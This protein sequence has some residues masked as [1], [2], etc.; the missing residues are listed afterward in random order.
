M[1]RKKL[2]AHLFEE[3][4]N[5]TECFDVKKANKLSSRR[6]YDHKINLILEVKLRTQKVYELAKNQAFVIKAYVNEMLKKGFIRSSSFRFAAPVLVVKKFGEGLRVCIDY[7]SLNALIIKNRNCSSL[8][9]ETLARLCAVKYYIKLDVIAVFNEIRIREGDEKKTTFFIKY[10]L[11]E[12]VV[13]PFGFCNAFE[14][15]QSYIN[16]VFREYL[17]DFCIVYLNDVLIYNNNK[18][19]HIKHVR[20]ILNKLHAVKLFLNINKCEFFVNEVKYLD[21]III[22]EGVKMNSKK[23]QVIFD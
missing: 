15:F 2:R 22:I 21:L 10:D 23:V 8:I 14:T 18:K 20:K 13:M 16:D 12:Y 7:R 3:L 9:R 1:S 17:N 6:D 4:K 19:N 11:Y 5:K